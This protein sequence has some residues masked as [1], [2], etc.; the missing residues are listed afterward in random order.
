MKYALIGSIV[1]FCLSLFAAKSGL[2]V[3]NW[4][5]SEPRGLYWLKHGHTSDR[6]L[7]LVCLTKGQEFP[8][9][10]AGL[11]PGRGSCPS[12]FQPILKHLYVASLQHPVEFDQF[13]FKVDGQRLHN[14]Q[15]LLHGRFG[16][17]FPRLASGRYTGGLFVISDYNARSYD[18]RYF[19]AVSQDQ[20][21]SFA[22]PVL[23]IP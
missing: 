19:G 17:T 22:V 2:V 6:D 13:G 23:V 10:V 11:D 21:I 5:G 8:A 12:G 20:I 7:V 15:P 1:L 18:S 9:I 4:T 16:V 3:F 14:T